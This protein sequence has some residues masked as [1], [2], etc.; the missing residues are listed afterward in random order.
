VPYP[1]FPFPGPVAADPLHWLRQEFNGA[2]DAEK[3]RLAKQL[4][5]RASTAGAKTEA[6]R[7]VAFLADGVVQS[8]VSKLLL[9]ADVEERLRHD[10]SLSSEIRAAAL[11]QA[12]QFVEDAD[13]LNTESWRIAARRSA[14]KEWYRQALRW[15]EAAVSHE[16]KNLAFV[17]TL[18]VLQY[19]NGLYREAI[20]NLMR[21]HEANRISETGPEPLDL[22]F[23]AMA[24]HALGETEKAREYFRQ[25]TSLCEQPAWKANQEANGFLNEARQRLATPP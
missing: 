13:K 4:M 11:L 17:N 22:S 2:N 20:A 18:G 6:N 12:A 16:P 23:L 5:E 9:R 21:S 15:A 7:W 14:E 24:H 8:L 25:L 19:R 10:A 1:A 3:P